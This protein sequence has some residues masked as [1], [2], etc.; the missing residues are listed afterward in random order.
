MSI[1]FS[2]HTLHPMDITTQH[3]LYTV[4]QTWKY[5]SKPIAILHVLD[6]ADVVLIGPSNNMND[7]KIIQNY[8][9]SL[10]ILCQINLVSHKT[11]ARGSVASNMLHRMHATKE[12][13]PCK[14]DSTIGNGKK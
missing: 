9:K 12:Q 5:F 6:V 1:N 2:T 7:D 10:D 3:K 13:N 4:K 8:T 11:H 14:R